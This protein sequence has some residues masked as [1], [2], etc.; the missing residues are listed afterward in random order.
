MV[1][2]RITGYL[3]FIDPRTGD[4]FFINKNSSFGKKVIRFLQ[5][6]RKTLPYRNRDISKVFKQFKL[7]ADIPIQDFSTNQRQPQP[8]WYY[9]IKRLQS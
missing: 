9:A 4:E 5:G 7:K 6:R 1:S 3:V 2:K 8:F